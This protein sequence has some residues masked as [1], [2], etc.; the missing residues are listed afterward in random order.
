MSTSL[1]PGAV[2][3]LSV[4][5]Y[6][7]IT[8][9]DEVHGSIGAAFQ[10]GR[11]FFCAP[12]AEK[13][14]STLPLDCGFRPRGVEYSSSPN[15]ADALESFT[16]STRTHEQGNALAS[17]R[18]RDLHQRMMLAFELLEPMA[19]ELMIQIAREVNSNKSHN[20]LEGALKR[21]SRLQLNYAVPSRTAEQFIN[22]LH[23]DGH[24]FTIASSTA[25]GLEV[26]A[27][28]GE[29]VPP[30]VGPREVLIMP[31]QILWLMTG[32]HIE[33]L[34]HRVRTIAEQSERMALLFFA[35]IGPTDCKPWI[36]NQA[37]ADVDIGARV[38]TNSSRFGV[39]DFP[40][41]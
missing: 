35:D 30:V 19:E 3:R 26:R 2:K 15:I 10:A 14:I 25:A 22:E 8:A 41:E 6:V 27:R 39:R 18:A 24:L 36:V 7:S 33:P 31:G 17:I 16:V 11:E 23:E 34:Y 4:D 5:G 12:V 29:F 37:N 28:S 13:L 32:G 1:P 38:L 20:D 21:W 9:S 40:L